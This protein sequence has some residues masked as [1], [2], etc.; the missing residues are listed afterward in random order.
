M[1]RH[2]RSPY[3][4]ELSIAASE[5]EQRYRDGEVGTSSMNFLAHALGLSFE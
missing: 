4:H 1:T 3:V 5:L 2:S